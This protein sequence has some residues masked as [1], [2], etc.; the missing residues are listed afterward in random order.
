MLTWMKQ[1]CYRLPYIV[2]LVT[3]CL[4]SQYRRF[5]WVRI[6]HK[7]LCLCCPFQYLCLSCLCISGVQLNPLQLVYP[8]SSNIFRPRVWHKEKSQQSSSN[9]PVPLSALSVLHF[10]C[11]PLTFF[12]NRVYILVIKNIF[13]ALTQRGIRFYT[14]YLLQHSK[15]LS[16]KSQQQ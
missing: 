16:L 15:S 9:V 11:Y 7:F 8:L 6:L 5:L 3:P 10:P 14:V 4:I 1:T 12:C 2:S 13:L